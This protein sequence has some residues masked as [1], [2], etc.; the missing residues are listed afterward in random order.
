MQHRLKAKEPPPGGPALNTGS[1][2]D[3]RAI[4]VAAAEAALLL[5]S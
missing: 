3:A 2:A 5:L 4:Q 1:C